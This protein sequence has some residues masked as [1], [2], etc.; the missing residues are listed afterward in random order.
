MTNTA[1][2][3]IEHLLASDGLLDEMA[4]SV[5]LQMFV[6]VCI[7]RH[8][9]GDWGDLDEHDKDLSDLGLAT[10][11][12]VWSA[13]RVPEFLGGPGRAGQYLYVTT[14]IGLN[15]TSMMFADEY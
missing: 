14:N 9:I 11:G 4:G 13:Y 1:A 6:G 10:G 3:E 8:S 2:I 7:G 12:N 5:F 15:L